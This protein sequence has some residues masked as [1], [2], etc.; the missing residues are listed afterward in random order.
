MESKVESSGHHNQ[1][2]EGLIFDSFNS[3]PIDKDI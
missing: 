2:D 1:L 3:L